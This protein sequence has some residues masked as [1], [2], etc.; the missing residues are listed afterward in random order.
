M[1]ENRLSNDHNKSTCNGST[2]VEQVV[3]RALVTQRARSGQVSWVRFFRGFSSPVRQMSGSFRPPRSPNIVWPSLSPIHIHY[4]RQWPEMLMRPKNLIYIHTR[5]MI[6][7]S[8]FSR[9]YPR[10][11]SGSIGSGTG[12]TQPREDNWVATWMRSS[13]IRLRKLKLRLRDKRFA[14]HKAPCGTIWQ[15]PLQSVL[16]LRGCSATDL[17]SNF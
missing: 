4:G 5:A 17:I 1:I 8:K 2:A 16:A 15:Q 7:N 12:P 3:A 9:L 13:E 11:F 10:N 6:A 14:N